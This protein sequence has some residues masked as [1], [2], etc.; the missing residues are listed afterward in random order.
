MTKQEYIHM[1]KEVVARF[2]PQIQAAR[3][4]GNDFEEGL[5]EGNVQALRHA[6]DLAAYLEEPKQ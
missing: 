1:L 5:Y 2:E 3:D 4:R 6:L